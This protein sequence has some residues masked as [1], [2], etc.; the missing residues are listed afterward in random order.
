MDALPMKK[1]T[2]TVSKEQA[3][4][5]EPYLKDTL[6]FTEERQGRTRI[7]V[8]V[9]DEMLEE[10]IEK[11][12]DALDAAK[13]TGSKFS[14]PV[15]TGLITRI[16]KTMDP[17]DEDV[18]VEVSSPDFVI[19]PALE[20]MK[21][22]VRMLRQPRSDMTIEKMVSQTEGYTRLDSRTVLLAGI[23]GMV[24]LIGLFLNNI[25][26][27][28]GAMLLAPLLGPIYA[29]AIQAAIGSM[30]DIG[31]CVRIIVL[32][33]AMLIGVAV[34]VTFSFSLVFPLPLTPEIAARMDANVIYIVMAILLGFAT[35]VA[36]SRGIPEGIAGVAIAAAL[37]P[38]AV[39]TGIALVIYPSGALKA[40]ILTLQ[41]VVGLVAGSILAVTTLEIGPR[42][43][44]QRF[45]ARKA[46]TRIVLIL[47][48]FIILL[49]GLSFVAG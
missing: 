4:K 9:L 46:L 3:E 24:G 43:L 13:G 48:V 19:S 27:V 45:R 12:Y 33:L 32:L 38:P 11:T 6:Y 29:L 10:M 41:N 44:F 26:I 21:E 17:A 5:L 36:L 47:A 20:K 22:R 37:L 34:L 18:L 8:F 49:T 25:G 40:F 31:R 1:V 16:E 14:R 42:D 23:A 39:V 28:I 15:W 2:I 7:T 35:I 30:Q